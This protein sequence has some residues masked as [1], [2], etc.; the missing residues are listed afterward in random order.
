M[1]AREKIDLGGNEVL[2]IVPWVKSLDTKP[3]FYP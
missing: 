1:E 2:A 3:D